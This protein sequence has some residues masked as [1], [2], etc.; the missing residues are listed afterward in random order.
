ML[1]TAKQPKNPIFTIE[2]NEVA[3][4]ANLSRKRPMSNPPEGGYKVTNIYVNS[5][6]KLIIEYEV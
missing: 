5:T 2:W 3:E 1:S 4:L 6:G